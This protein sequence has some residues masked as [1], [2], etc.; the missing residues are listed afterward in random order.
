VLEPGLDYVILVG[1]DGYLN[2]EVQLSTKGF[3]S[4]KRL[5]YKLGLEKVENRSFV[6][7]NIYYDF[8]KADLQ[9]EAF[10]AL[11][12]TIYKVLKENPTIIV[13]IGSYTDNKGTAA[14]NLNLSQGRA[15]SVVKYLSRKGIDKKRMVA[16]GYGESNPVARNENSDGS[17]NPEGRAKNRRTEFKVIGEIEVEYI[18]D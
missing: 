12:T 3:A 15:E 13:E 1:A 8:G 10:L 14:Y 11:D 6:M 16:K 4:D 2:K 17:D 18:E 5:S 9:D 7:Q